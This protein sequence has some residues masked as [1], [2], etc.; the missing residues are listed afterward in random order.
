MFLGFSVGK[1]RMDSRISI[2]EKKSRS[3]SE[4]GE[5]RTSKDTE[6]NE[7]PSSSP[8]RS[9]NDDPPTSHSSCENSSRKS[10][11]SQ[12]RSGP[13]G[14]G[15]PPPGD[16]EF[17][18]TLRKNA[19]LLMVTGGI[20]GFMV[21]SLKSATDVP[22]TS[23]QEFIATVLPTGRVKSI[24]VLDGNRVEVAMADGIQGCHFTIGDAGAFEQK[25]D[26]AQRRL[27]WKDEEFL[28]VI[29]R[30]PSRFWDIVLAL[31]FTIAIMLPFLYGMRHVGGG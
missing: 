16:D 20:L 10:E 27:G 17:L 8:K 6:S 22:A 26:Y 18:E 21:Y 23:F 12:K 7:K 14:G 13:G 25:L 28:P 11:S 2:D 3:G 15:K 29:Y 30:N 31:A 19:S 9:D 4:N 1:L 24:S 5:N